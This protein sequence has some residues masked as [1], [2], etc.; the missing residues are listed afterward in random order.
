MKYLIDGSLDVK[1]KGAHVIAN[2]TDGEFIF[3]TD[4]DAKDQ[5]NKATLRGIAEANDVIVGSKDNVATLVKKLDQ[6]F[7]KLKLLEVNEMSDE[8]KVEEI[9][10]AGV[11]AEKDHD[12]MLVEIVNA[13]VSFKNAVKLFKRVMESKGFAITAKKRAEK[14]QG[15]IEELEFNAESGEDV[16]GMIAHIVKNV[17][18]TNEKQALGVL[19]RW[20]KK[21]EI[22]LPKP[23]KKAGGAGG[24]R[25]KAFDWMIAN[26]TAES[27]EFFKWAVED[28][29]RKETVAK[30][31]V[32]LFEVSKK[33]AEAIIAAGDSDDAEAA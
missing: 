6:N 24:F 21:E 29:G 30:R 5:L 10:V 14:I 28:Q 2:E 15:L 22:E 25:A 11:E 7:S 26:P 12:T 33:I 1:W 4:A 27:E 31:F 23:E 9:V 17:P 32:G 13:G 18:D 19:R 8:A 16:S 3:D 20:A